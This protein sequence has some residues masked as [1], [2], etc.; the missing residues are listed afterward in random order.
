MLNF[1]AI[2][3]DL[4]IRKCIYAALI[5][6]EQSKA[7]TSLGTFG[8]TVVT[9]VGN[10]ARYVGRIVGTAPED[11]VGLVIGDPLHTLRTIAA[12]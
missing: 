7:V 12:A 8:T 9:E 1:S 2:I 5:T 4:D 10:L 6:N 3:I 11:A